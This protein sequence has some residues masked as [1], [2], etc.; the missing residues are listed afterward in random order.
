MMIMKIKNLLI[1][2]MV[3]LALLQSEADKISDQ[4]S[5]DGSAASYFD[6]DVEEDML[7]TIKIE[8]GKRLLLLADVES[9]QESKNAG[10]SRKNTTS[11][12][13]MVAAC[14]IGS[15]YALGYC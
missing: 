12:C 11:R 7:P 8:N 6:Q 13:T 10:A 14:W 4:Q 9:V 5:V 2:Y 15:I 3:L 1:L